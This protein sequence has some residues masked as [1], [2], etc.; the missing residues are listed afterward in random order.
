VMRRKSCGRPEFVDRGVYLCLV[1][2]YILIYT[3]L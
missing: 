1:D 2:R 3:S